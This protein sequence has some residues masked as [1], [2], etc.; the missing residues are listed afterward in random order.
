VAR[1][2]LSLADAFGQD[3]GGGRILVRKK[4]TQTDLGA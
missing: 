3:V 1:A 2:L 4:V